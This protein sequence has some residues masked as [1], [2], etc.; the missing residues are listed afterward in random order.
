MA[1]KKN[2]LILGGNG[3]IGSNLG[4]QLLKENYEVVSFDQVLPETPIDDIQY[5]SGDFF[6]D[7]TL[8]NLVQGKDIIYHAI[9]TINPGN[10]N[11]GYMRGYEKD[12]L[13]TV[14]LCELL[15]GAKTKLIFLSSGGTVYGKQ[16]TL[17]IPETALPRPINHYGN[18]KLCIENTMLTFA[19]QNG[20]DVVIA[21]IANPYGPGQDYH[22]GVGFIDAAIKKAISG[23][24]IEVWGDGQIVRDYIYIDDVCKALV[25]IAHQE[26]YSD[27][28][29]NI[30]SGKG[31]SVNQILDI[32]RD[33]NGTIDVQYQ[34]ARSVDLDKVIL[35]NRKLKIILPGKIT[36]INSG[37]EMYYNWIKHHMNS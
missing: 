21:R 4:K 22:K 24:I 1:N 27:K 5:I 31:I 37:I 3:F 26:E 9:S 32:I 14:K 17:P 8:R 19:Y 25:A 2:A 36:D 34:E 11:Q 29:I 7:V 12:F 23:E 10:S 13:Q 30:S 16:S 18:L 28:I 35:D 15:E 33:I 6:D 20:I